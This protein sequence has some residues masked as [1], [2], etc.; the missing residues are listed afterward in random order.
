M[1]EYVSGPAS[2]LL[3]VISVVGFDFD[4]ALCDYIHTNKHIHV[5][6]QPFHGNHFTIN[7]SIN[8]Q[9]YSQQI[10]I[11]NNA[12]YEALTMHLR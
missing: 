8:C 2:A 11:S 12:R 1:A 9:Q 7:H 6:L 10:S 3:V 4:L 5:W